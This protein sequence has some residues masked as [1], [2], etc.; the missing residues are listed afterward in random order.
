MFSGNSLGLYL[1]SLSALGLRGQ[2]GSAT[3]GQ[4]GERAYVN[5]FTGNLVLQRADVLL[6]GRGPDAAALRTYN[7]QGGYDFDGN[8]D[9]WQGAPTRAIEDLGGGKL[10]RHD[11]DGSF[12]DYP[13][14]ATRQAYLA[15]V[16]AG[17]ARDAIVVNADGT[18]T[19]TD[20]A[21]G[22]RETYQA[23]SFGR[24]LTSV[25]AS[26]NALTYGYD[27]SNLLT[28]I[29]SASGESITF[30]Y[31]GPSGRNLLEVR[32]VLSIDGA[33][34]VLDVSYGYDALNRLE[35][36]SVVL[37]PRSLAAVAAGETG[38]VFK[39]TYAYDGTSNRVAGLTQGDG[40]TL[41]FTYVLLDGLYKVASVTD[42][43][44]KV[45]QFAYDA[46]AGRTTVTD[47]LGVATV[48]QHDAKGQLTQV[49][50]GVTAGNPAGRTRLDYAYTALGDVASIV[51]GLGRTVA[52]TYDASGNLLR[53][54]DAAGNTLER[55]YDAR[56][57]LLTE[58]AHAGAGATQPLTTRYVRD[59][60]QRGLLRFVLSAEG[61]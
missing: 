10:R 52:M 49:R 46:A 38:T 40:T 12:C 14:D 59:A 47:P 16:T 58:S 3:Q 32:T 7:S 31:G 25:D 11:A 60:A 54:V 42:G 5:A 53:Q 13:W 43:E 34:T 2:S 44:G 29:S 22:G 18:Y 21:S 51:D 1:S 8:A 56:N 20:G 50:S 9:G 36:V 48:Y 28:R 55:T 61:G 41:S 30:T 37:N 57:Q 35:S 17:S 23:G 15:S 19:W 24:I 39:T 26:G 4:G 33:L 27:A 6:A 45:T